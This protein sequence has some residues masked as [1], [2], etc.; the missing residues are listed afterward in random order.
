MTKKGT[1]QL[2]ESKLYMFK[3]GFL[4]AVENDDEAGAKKWKAGYIATR[5][6]IYDLKKS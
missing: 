1:I 5:N 4:R 6:R 3:S 2:L